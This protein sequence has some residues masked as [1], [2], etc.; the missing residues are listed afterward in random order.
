ML[1]RQV[2]TPPN[3]VTIIGDL[4]QNVWINYSRVHNSLIILLCT[5][6]KGYRLSRPIKKMY[7]NQY[8]EYMV[9][10]KHLLTW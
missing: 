1:K 9:G 3:V 8:L 6:E 4:I 2:C 5:I 7:I 10:Y